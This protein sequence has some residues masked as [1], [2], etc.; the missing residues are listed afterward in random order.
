MGYPMVDDLEQRIIVKIFDDEEYEKLG[1]LTISAEI[2]KYIRDKIDFNELEDFSTKT[3]EFH[4]VPKVFSPE[5]EIPI[6]YCKKWKLG[7]GARIM[8]IE[9]CSYQI[10]FDSESEIDEVEGDKIFPSLKKEEEKGNLIFERWRLDKDSGNSVSGSLNFHSYVGKSFFDFIV[11]GMKSKPHPFEVRS[12]KIDYQDQYPAM[13]GDLSNAASALI[14][15]RGSPLYQ[16]FDF[17]ERTRETYYEDFMFLEYLFRPNQLPQ[18]Y[19]YVLHHLFNKLDS[20]VED[21]PINDASNVGSKEIIE[22]VSNPSNLYKTEDPPEKWP[23]SMEGYVP[24]S[25]TMEV[26]DE[27]IDTPE[28]RLL[29]NLLTSVEKMIVMLKNSKYGQE[30][31]YISDKLDEFESTIN[32]Y[33]SHDWINDVGE[34]QYV[35]TNSQVL[36]KREGYRDIFRYFINF[37][38]AFSLQWEEMRDCLQGYNRR[39]SEL[40]EYWCF[41]KLVNVMEDISGD[42]VDYKD[43]FETREWSLKM[44]RGNR[45]RIPFE[46]E[47]KGVDLDVE[48]MYNKT[49]SRH[50]REP[51]YSLPFRPDYTVLIKKGG[52]PFFIHFDAKYRSEKEVIEV[53]DKIG[54]E[55]IQEDWEKVGDDTEKAE[56]INEEETKTKTYKNADIYKM[57]TYKDAI[58]STHGSYI[59]YP[60]DEDAIFRVYNDRPIPSVGAFPLTPGERSGADESNLED[61]ILSFLEQIVRL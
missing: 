22:M 21:K 4:N 39:L 46:M 61:V 18:A 60:G 5:T 32:E 31:G 44:K 51:S 26:M 2:P 35:P 27:S 59:L 49:F 8:L 50:T 48:L 20:L 36:Q 42:K 52:D 23:S 37:N 9:E 12:R 58:V 43:L 6:E 24:L 15:E 17:G 19:R 1:E 38:F 13:I 16:D 40:Y 7:A 45:S 14:Y 41:F 56:K 55:E 3:M 33:L 30:E 54:S 29:K 28:N 25:V 11:G 57:H 10:R 34:L 53:Y 47:F